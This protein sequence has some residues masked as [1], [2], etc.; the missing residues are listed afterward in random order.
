[1]KSRLL[2]KGGRQLERWLPAGVFQ[3]KSRPTPARCRRSSGFRGGLNSFVRSVFKTAVVAAI[4]F[5]TYLAAAEPVR[6]AC[7]GDSITFG[8]GLRQT[9]PARLGQW[10]GT[11]YN[12]RNFGVSATTLLHRGDYPYIWR[13]DYTNALDFKA[14]IVV[15]NFG[16]NDSK[17]PN[18]G[19]LDATN[20]V[21]NWQHKGDFIGDYKA[22]IAAFRAA[23]PAAKI[24]IC[25]PTPDFPGRWGIND[26]TIREEMIP[27]IRMVA[28]EAGAGVIDLRSALAGR[29]EL[30]PDTVH[31]NDDGAKL[32]AAEIFRALMGQSPPKDKDEPG[33]SAAQRPGRANQ[34]KLFPPC[35]AWNNNF[36]G[37]DIGWH[38]GEGDAP[39][40]TANFDFATNGLYGYP[41][42]IR[43]WHYGWN[44]AGDNLF[45]KKLSATTRIPCSFS[46]NSGGDDLCGNFAYDL[47]LR[48]D[49]KKAAPQL[50]VMVWA[51]NNST[52]IGK[53]IATN[54]IVADGVSFDLWAGTNSGAGYY[55]YSFAPHEK[56]A[57]LPAGGSLNVDMMEFFK[58]LA[59]RDYFSMDMYLDVV[60]AGFEIV[61]GKGWVACG[62]FSCEAE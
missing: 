16:A 41:A 62:W 34:Y 37:S 43:G 45:P 36:H 8:W 59:G 5:T 15:I 40:W 23:N 50:E 32:M 35:F 56:T 58:L 4:L 30:F 26:R 17:H 3:G 31:P 61:R 51:G 48:H 14:D 18:D 28:E 21:N 57:K 38:P 49:D 52:P 33:A 2:Q 12:V 19:S 46:Y 44:P 27:M 13:P 6:V 42:S 55:V 1:M 54:I 11:N 25:H 9:Y 39:Q 24:F 22:M 53:P 29:A 10:L 47:F 7:V 20:A 60:E